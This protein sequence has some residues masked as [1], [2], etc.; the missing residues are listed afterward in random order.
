MQKGQGKK[1]RGGMTRE[2]SEQIF[3]KGEWTTW[4]GIMGRKMQPFEN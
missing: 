4:E 3:R 1:K 2:K